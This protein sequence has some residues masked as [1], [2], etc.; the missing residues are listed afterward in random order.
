MRTHIICPHLRTPKPK[1]ALIHTLHTCNLWVF[2]TKANKSYPQFIYVENSFKNPY[3]G[4]RNNLKMWK[5]QKQPFFYVF[6]MWIIIE[7][8]GT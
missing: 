4:K 2:H 6:L 3:R 1:N 8:L 5:T 7:C